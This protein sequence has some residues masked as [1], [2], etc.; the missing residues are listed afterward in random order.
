MLYYVTGDMFSREYNAIVNPVN[1][2][3]VMGKGVAKIVKEKFPDII[4]PYKKKCSSKKLVPGSTWVYRTGINSPKYI[5]NTATKNHWRDLST[6]NTVIF[7]YN[8]I[9]KAIKDKK[10]TNIAIP[11]LG[12]G[13]G[14]LDWNT[15][16]LLA[17]D[18]LESSD[19]NGTDI[20]LYEPYTK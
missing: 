20:Y 2:V 7:C 19:L 8:S 6:I 16:K 9:V 17:V 14:G 1:C 13:N 12:C 15:I 11:P 18:I 5:L 4:E 10:I 3:G